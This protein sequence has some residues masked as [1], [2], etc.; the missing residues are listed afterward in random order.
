MPVTR[1]PIAILEVTTEEEAVLTLH[2]LLSMRGHP[3]H[4][5][6]S[7]EVYAPIASRLALSDRDA[8]TMLPGGGMSTESFSQVAESLTVHDVKLV[9]L[10]RFSCTNLKLAARY[11][12]FFRT[13][14][15][16]V[17]A[18]DHRRWF[19][20]LPPL[21]FNGRKLIKLGRVLEWVTARMVFRAAASF[22]VS[23]PHRDSSNPLRSRFLVAGKPAF[24]VPFRL[25]AKDYRPTTDFTEV[26][27]VIPGKIDGERR[28]YLGLLKSIKK[29][30][31]AHA[32][33]LVLLGRP[34]GAYGRRVLAAA[35]RLNRSSK[36]PLVQYF[37]EYVSREEFE[38]VLAQATHVVGPA[39]GRT[40]GKG[41]DSGA[42]YDVFRCNKVGIFDEDYFY[43]QRSPLRKA[44][45]TYRGPRELRD[46]LR[47]VVSGEFDYRSLEAQFAHVA[48]YLATRSYV[49]HVG[50]NIDQIV[51]GAQPVG[52]TPP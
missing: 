45:V 48:D 39:P 33:R 51:P 43:D 16:C 10:P 21:V 42:L 32:W 7:D 46:V 4:L 22:F 52:R 38:R 35:E 40:Y 5:F 1:E 25:A 3:V 8:V 49:D 12:E 24:E 26:V 50:R 41:K 18:F 34:V 6:L 11:R 20:A 27:F 17:G 37:S 15:T 30:D 31:Q 28:D 44:L 19:G 14:A 29:L 13:F 2:T 47:R 36:R 9:V 23:D